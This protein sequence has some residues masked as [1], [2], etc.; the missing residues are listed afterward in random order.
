MEKGC[1]IY[2]NI[3]LG[4]FNKE[5]YQRQ[6]G[7]L[8][9]DKRSIPPEDTVILNVHVSNNKAAKCETKTDKAERRKTNSIYSQ[10][11]ISHFQQLIEQLNRKPARLSKNSTIPST[12]RI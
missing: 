3:R 1:H 7:T 11:S 6:R 8:Y 4:R 12:N 2:T 9:N 10:M 5:N